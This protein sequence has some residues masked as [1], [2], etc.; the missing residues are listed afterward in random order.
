MLIEAGW[1]SAGV[2][3]LIKFYVDCP[4]DSAK[5]TVLGTTTLSLYHRL[6]I[7]FRRT[8]GVQLEHFSIGCNYRLVYLR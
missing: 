1:L 7:F 4:I 5:Q 6:M 2:T 3:W 8:G